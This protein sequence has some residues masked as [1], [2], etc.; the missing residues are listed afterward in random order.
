MTVRSAVLGTGQFSDNV[1]H[2]LYTCPVGKV[3][4]VKGL[5]FGLNANVSLNPALFVLSDS[6]GAAETVLSWYGFGSGP[7]P[8][9]PLGGNNT[10]WHVLEAGDTVSCLSQG[11]GDTYSITVS[12]A[13]LDLP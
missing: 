5:S 7:S 9:L 2:A 11:P 6:T 4:I 1:P 3:A 12:G 8:Y 13:E 10:C